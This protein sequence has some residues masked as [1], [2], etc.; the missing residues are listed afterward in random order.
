MMKQ[1]TLKCFFKHF[2]AFQLMLKR[3]KWE[4]F[5]PKK[6]KKQGNVCSVR[7]LRTSDFKWPNFQSYLDLVVIEAKSTPLHCMAF[8]FQ[9]SYLT[10][11]YGGALWDNAKI[12]ANRVEQRR[13]RGFHKPKRL[14]SFSLHLSEEALKKTQTIFS[15]HFL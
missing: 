14:Q 5:S 4:E 7:T 2:K 1:Q 12:K 8:Y 6:S 9:W 13:Q 3:D 15:L 11:I 10:K